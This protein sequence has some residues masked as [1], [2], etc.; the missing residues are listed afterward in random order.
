M[1]FLLDEVKEDPT[2]KLELNILSGLK[3]TGKRVMLQVHHKLYFW[4]KL[5]WQYD[6]KHLQT[7]CYDCHMQVHKNSKILM[8]K[9]ETM[10]L[11]AT[12]QICKRCEGT[13][14]FHQYSHIKHGVCFDCWGSGNYYTEEPNW[15]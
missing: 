14:Y 8:Y 7:L 6:R 5:P 1:K 15:V 12:P 10:T 4:N 11:K 2:P 3:P 13:G 9:D